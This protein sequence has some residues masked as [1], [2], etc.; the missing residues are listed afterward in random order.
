MGHDNPVTPLAPTA[1]KPQAVQRLRP[2]CASG[3]NSPPAPRRASGSWH[4]LLSRFWTEWLEDRAL[5]RAAARHQCPEHPSNE[6]CCWLSPGWLAAGLW[7]SARYEIACSCPDLLLYTQPWPCVALSLS[8]SD[9][10][11]YHLTF[12]V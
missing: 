9:S 10:C 7:R 1:P 6:S 4:F 12:Q 3:C 11:S 5:E 8:T 2:P